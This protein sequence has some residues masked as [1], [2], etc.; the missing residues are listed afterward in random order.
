MIMK[1]AP[2]SYLGSIHVLVPVI[3][4][5]YKLRRIGFC[6]L[7]ESSSAGIIP[8]FVVCALLGASSFSLLPLVLEY[9]VEITYPFPPEIG[10]TLCWTGGQNPYGLTE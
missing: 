5:S 6:A 4:L 3:A 8:S 2:K 10:S 7:Q 9:L 1:T